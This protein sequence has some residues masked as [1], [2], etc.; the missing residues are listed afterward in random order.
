MQGVIFPTRLQNGKG[1]DYDRLQRD[2]IGKQIRS[3]FSQFISE[4]IRK[5]S[6]QEKRENK[7]GFTRENI[8]IET[9]MTINMV[10]GII[11]RKNITKKRD[12]VIAICRAIGLGLYD[13][14]EALKRYPMPILDP[15]NMRDLVIIDAIRENRSTAAINDSLLA[16]GF[17]KLDLSGRRNM[18]REHEYTYYS[19]DEML[20]KKYEKLWCE[21]ELYNDRKSTSA[22]TELSSLYVP[23]MFRYEAVLELKRLSDNGIIRFT[24]PRDPLEREWYKDND[25]QFDEELHLYDA[26]LKHEIDEKMQYVK[27]MLDDTKYYGHRYSMEIVDG[28]LVIFGEWFSIDN[29]ELE[30]YYQISVLSGRY[31]FSASKRSRFLRR[32]LG[33]HYVDYYST[34]VWEAESIT[35]KPLE[36]IKKIAERRIVETINEADRCLT[37]RENEQETKMARRLLRN[38]DRLKLGA[39]ELLKR[40]R[41]QRTV[42]YIPD[43]YKDI[44]G[45]FQL[46]GAL[47]FLEDGQ[48]G[49]LV[50]Q[51]ASLS[52]GDGIEVTPKELYRC[53]ELGL[54][55]IDEVKKAKAKYGEID[56]ILKI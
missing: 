50:P 10:K 41:D 9:G 27:N 46:N 35:A 49:Q 2:T 47:Q 7:S 30:E 37:A 38:I 43:G 23:D 51:V 4:K 3:G 53:L 8:A 25:V 28:E 22:Q 16:A 26:R 12:A 11:N 40:L 42:Y 55:T 32:Y 13:T 18:D 29:P 21:V 19:A 54:F 36:E 39:E 6:M 45:I 15:A 31:T 5:R 52:L 24:Y 33:V 34:D 44:E 56:G 20:G 1:Y 14:N 17:R 48:T